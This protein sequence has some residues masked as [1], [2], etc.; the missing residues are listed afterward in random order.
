MLGVGMTTLRCYGAPVTVYDE[1]R[2]M[3]AWIVVAQAAADAEPWLGTKELI[4]LLGNAIFF[5]IL[6]AIWYVSRIFPQW[7]ARQIERQKARAADFAGT[8]DGDDADL[9]P[10]M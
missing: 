3:D 6:G 4:V 8:S 1:E 10:R 2:V 5:G 7:E 9:A